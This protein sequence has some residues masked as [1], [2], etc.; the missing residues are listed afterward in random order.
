MPRLI[1]LMSGTSLDGV[2]AAWLDTDGVH[3]NA[4]GPSLTLSYDADLRRDLRVLL[5]FA[6]T[7]DPD[8]P[9]LLSAV[10]RLTEY[11]VRAVKAL[12]R[13]ADMIGCHG[14]TILH[15]PCR[16]RTWQVGDA[17]SLAGRHRRRRAGG[18]AGSHLPRSPGGE[19]SQ[20]TSGAEYRRHCEC[21]LDRGRR[22][23]CRLRHRTRQRPA[24][25]LVREA[26]RPAI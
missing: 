26:H 10:E 16:R 8:D 4:F 23:V 6:P 13:S 1:G 9:R 12:D 18:S 11:H 7:L 3:I 19:P 24:R 21:D 20:A 2:D 14:Q 17:A 15:Q 22:R 5:D 25:R